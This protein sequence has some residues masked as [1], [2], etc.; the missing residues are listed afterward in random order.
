[1]K[2]DFSLILEK[3]SRAPKSLDEEELA[4]LLA[5]GD[6]S[7]EEKALFEAAYKIKVFQV[8]RNISVRGLIEAGNICQK[9]CYYCGIRKSNSSVER[10]S[11][12]KEKIVALAKQA[13]DFGFASIVI[14]SGE[15]ESGKHT[16]FIE[17]VLREIAPLELGVTL[18]LG[19]QSCE[20]LRRWREAG[21]ARYLLRI[22]T[23]NK[24]LYSKLHP[25]DHS[26]ER[27]VEVLKDLGDLGYQV[28]TGVM[29]GLPGQTLN[30]LARDILFFGS[31]DADMIGMGPWI[32]H[33][34][35]PL[36]GE[37]DKFH[38]LKLGLKMIAATRLYLHDI[39]IAASTALEALA[40]NGRV[41][42]ILAG[43]NVIMPNI[44]DEQYKKAYNLYDGKPG[45]C[46]S[47]LVAR[48]LLDKKLGEIGEKILY[49]QR[50][51]SL[52]YAKK[53]CCNK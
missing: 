50:G 25:S 36:K 31:C 16:D 21:A 53:S 43:A 10:Y 14:Q 7:E 20:T 4:A 46:E 6:G 49:A 1:M 23:S 13:K 41:L 39:N 28:G 19:E 3:A 11:L 22:E 9:D 40:A 33:K 47:A 51:D 52:H 8:E 2:H 37:F 27:R 24:K 44:T 18:S 34:D 26:W 17:E 15:I 42:G 5:C 38:A 32:P 30:D 48:N 35:T 29:I 12:S 45:V